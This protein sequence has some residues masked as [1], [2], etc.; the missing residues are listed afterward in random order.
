MYIC[1]HINKSE[2]YFFTKHKP[3]II[4]KTSIQVLTSVYYYII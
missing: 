3:E 1:L 4:Q 2:Y